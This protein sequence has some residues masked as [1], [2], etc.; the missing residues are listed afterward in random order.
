M[1]VFVSEYVTGGGWPEGT[2][3]GS[4]AV[5]GRAMLCAVVDDLSRIAGVRVETTWDARLGPSPFVSARAVVARSP[6]E[7]FNDVLECVEES[8]DV[9]RVVLAHRSWDMLGLVGREQAETMLRQSVRYCVKQEL[10][11]LPRKVPW[12]QRLGGTIWRFCR[13]A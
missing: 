6:D 1:R 4:L 12:W 5:E 8:P 10:I 2:I 7:A 11:K 13:R 3:A 9:H